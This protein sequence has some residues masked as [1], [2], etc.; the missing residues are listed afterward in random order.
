[1]ATQVRISGTLHTPRRIMR[2]TVSS[3][4]MLASWKWVWILLSLRRLMCSST[5][6]G[7]AGMVISR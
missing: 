1:M 6:A 5:Q 4:A 7:P 2:S 3:W